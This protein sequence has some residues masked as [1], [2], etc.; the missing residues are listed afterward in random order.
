[1][2]FRTGT[3]GRWAR[4]VAFAL[5]P[6][7]LLLFGMEMGF[8]RWGGRLLFTLPT[9]L[10]PLHGH[11]CLRPSLRQGWAPIPGRCGRNRLGLYGDEVSLPPDPE[12]HEILLLGD[13]ISARRYWVAG[14]RRLEEAARDGAPVTVWNAA[15]SG[16]NPCQEIHSFRFLLGHLQPDRVLVQLCAN[17]LERSPVLIRLPGGFIRYVSARADLTFPGPVLRSRLATYL[18]LRGASAWGTGMGSE[19]SAEPPTLTCLEGMAALAQE[20][21][22]PLAMVLFPVFDAAVP[23]EREQALRADEERLRAMVEDLDDVT[24]CDLRPAFE[25]ALEEGP[26]I[27]LTGYREK[28]GDF[29]HPSRSAQDLAAEEIH[30]CLARAPAP[31]G[32]AGR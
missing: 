15:V 3:L 20:A 25:R 4:R 9:G 1:M 11:P 28:S 26:A 14:L 13:S 8:R 21:E 19:D 31:V 16:Y 24:F 29:V 27:D 7:S 30:R 5:I 12:A 6:V 18:V 2:T 23:S 32:D 10:P 22:I 17:D